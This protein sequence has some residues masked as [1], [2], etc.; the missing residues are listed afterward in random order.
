MND[1]P[2]QPVRFYAVWR[3]RLIQR[4]MQWGFREETLLIFIAAV[5][6]LASGAAAWVFKWWVEF[7]A[8]NLLEKSALASTGW[9]R[10]IVIVLIPLLGGL[11]LGLAKI[12][13]RTENSAFTG[14]TR[15]LL[16]LIQSG[17][18]LPHKTSLETLVCSGLTIGSGG[19]AGPEAPIA[20][21]GSSIGS[22]LGSLIGISRRHLPTLIGCGAAAGI[23]AVFD[24][25]IAG[26]LFAL[27]VML[28]DFSIKTF[29]PIVVSAVIGT[30]LFHSLLQ[31]TTGQSLHGLFEMSE[32]HIFRFTLAD[33]PYYMLLG[34]SCGMIAILFT[35][36]LRTAG[37]CSSRLTKIPTLLKPAIGAG[38]SGLCGALL[39]FLFRNEPYLHHRF[40]TDAYVPLFGGGYPTI[41][42]LIDPSW[43]RTGLHFVESV[44]VI[45]SLKFM[46][47]LV[48]FKILATALT[49][50]FGGSGGVFAPSLFIGASAGGA[51][52]AAIGLII[53]GADPAAYALVGMAAVLAA[54]IQAP[55]M[56][57]LLIF[58]ISRNY[59]A[60]LPG[61]FTAV[62]ATVLFQ[63][64]FKEGIYT[65]PL[66]E[67][68]I[69]AGSPAGLSQIRRITLDQTTLIPVVSAKPGDSIPEIMKLIHDNESSDLAVIDERGKYLGL[70]I[71]SDLQNVLLRPEAA[72]LLLAGD[73]CRW[74]IPPL[75]LT[76][77]LETA[78]DLFAKYDSNS[79][80]VIP[81][82][83]PDAP[84]GML[85]RAEAMKH[86]AHAMG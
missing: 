69:R 67:K 65:I 28:R 48:A 32:G 50:G 15:V 6:G 80:V 30:T 74:E 37:K 79:L 83:H 85:T 57:I 86:Y 73:I 78:I 7:V 77:S 66:R 41:L 56:S 34:I 76:D 19:S 70:I 45:L 13:F 40:I 21:I 22:S 4:L 24:A 9:L 53:P 38:L 33:L 46:I 36:A 35:A 60:M 54:V 47:C 64:V 68:G 16:S 5:I 72:P 82:N 42:R 27:E 29:T 51:F 39:I 8:H 55:L 63:F 52:G 11:L 10:Y 75:L 1:Q 71:N 26:V 62:I 3:Y 18:K 20:V 43:H 17:G 44:P 59:N 58:E 49:L 81:H 23:G 14:L 84:V 31:T 61:M 2:D 25:P 12:L